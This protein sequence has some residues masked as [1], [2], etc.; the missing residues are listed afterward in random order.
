MAGDNGSAQESGIKLSQA[1]PETREFRKQ[2][3]RPPVI[4]CNVA[5]NSEAECRNSDF[6]NV[7]DKLLFDEMKSIHQPSHLM[8]APSILL[9]LAG[10]S[11][12][13][14]AQTYVPVETTAP[15]V[16]E[17]SLMDCIQS[18]LNN[19]LDLQVARYTLPQAQLALEAAYA[20]YDP[21]F[22][23]SGRHNFSL[24]QGNFS[25]VTATNTPSSVVNGNNFSTSLG[26]LLP[27]GLNYTL[28]GN[29]GE[30]YGQQLRP[31]DSSSGSASVNLTQPLLK[32]FWIDQTRL[33]IRI[34]RNRLKYTDNGW[35]LSLMRTITSVEQAYYDL[36]A[37]RENVKVQ[38]KAVQLAEQ[39]VSENTKRVEVG[40][41]APL[42]QK[43]A[44]SQAASS[45][46]S[47]IAAKSTLAVQE[48]NL[49]QLVS[50]NFAGWQSVDIQPTLTLTAPIHV[51]DLQNS[52]STGLT[53][54][55]DLLQAKLDVEQQGVTLK[56]N[57]NQL[58]PEL[59]LT[60]SY[61]HNAGG[62][63]EFHQAFDQLRQG[64]QPNYFYGAQLTIPLANTAARAN[65]KRGK[66]TMETLV[67]NLKQME[68]TIMVTI[69]NDIKQAQSSYEQVAAT[70]AARE[71][72]QD[73]YDA[74]EKKLQ[75]GKS[76]TYTVLQMQR[77]LTAARGNEIQALTTY[78]KNLSQCTT[79]LFRLSVMTS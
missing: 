3:R 59:D 56:Y 18:A 2:V 29:V 61:G 72:A 7:W 51:F 21:Q 9:V 71:Y 70:R 19:N 16:K 4:S 27:W 26:G 66:L 33:N 25:T 73:A 44:E 54:R 78:N 37:A 52:W 24:S 64:N 14:L 22:S 43:Q 13:A 38:D 1:R 40:A 45:Q 60:G 30:S 39:L 79:A 17:M 28:S 74:E 42:D 57:F 31:F 68:Q 69:D 5:V 50:D 23:I 12:T 35:K 8:R 63:R 58:F 36:I 48:N 62:G 10:M 46:A 53:Q 6:L 20:G 41:M 76:T 75:Q 32:N 77:D 67:L 49:K 15:A 47:L 65:Y 11:M 34:A 55:P